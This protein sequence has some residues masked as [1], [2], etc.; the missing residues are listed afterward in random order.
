[1]ANCVYCGKGA[2]LFRSKHETCEYVYYAGRRK[3][4]TLTAQAVIQPEFDEIELR[5][6]LTSIARGSF[7]SQAGINGAIAAG[8]R[9]AANVRPSSRVDVQEWEERLLEAYNRLAVTDHQSNTIARSIRDRGT[10]RATGRL[11]AIAREAASPGA[12]SEV[13][14]QELQRVLDDSELSPEQ[15]RDVLIDAWEEEARIATKDGVIAA[16]ETMALERYRTLFNL[17]YLELDRRGAYTL[18]AKVALIGELANGTIPEL[19]DVPNLPVNLQSSEQLIWA[20][21]NVDYYQTITHSEFRGDSQGLGLPVTKGVYYNPQQIRG[22][23]HEWNETVRTGPGFLG[24]TTRHLY[25]HGGGKSFRISYSE[26]VSFHQTQDGFG[27]TRD[28]RDAKPERFR[29]GDGWFAYGLVT[30]LARL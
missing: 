10:K 9:E 15:Q 1:M 16:E 19:T 5:K 4:V 18:Y 28:E 26:I 20:F 8:W 13:K 12:D 22:R 3:M 25:F 6:A 2:G 21:N 14:I 17:S 30:R 23:F 29:T 24:I 11:I 27:L 7:I